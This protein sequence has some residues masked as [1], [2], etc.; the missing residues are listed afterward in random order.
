MCTWP[1]C[2]RVRG[3]AFTNHDH[4]T[5][6]SNS[7]VVLGLKRKGRWNISILLRKNYKLE[8][9]GSTLPRTEVPYPVRSSAALA[10]QTPSLAFSIYSC[11]VS[12]M[13]QCPHLP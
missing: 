13:P 9:P 6:V 4:L 8:T 2:W 1:A 12:F 10:L 7:H 5:M 11:Y 3:E